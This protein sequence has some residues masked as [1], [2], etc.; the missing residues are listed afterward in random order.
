[1]ELEVD[2]FSVLPEL[3]DE[4]FYTW[5]TW[6]QFYRV[7]KYPLDSDVQYSSTQCVW[8]AQCIV[9]HSSSYELFHFLL[10][11]CFII[12]LLYLLIWLIYYIFYKCKKDKNPLKHVVKRLR[13][14]WLITMLFFPLLFF[15]ITI[16]SI[17]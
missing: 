6:I 10:W 14:E 13:L 8:S 16:I 15:V 5:N 3:S 17:K 2:W 7:S 11:A 12:T 1:M 9:S 4:G